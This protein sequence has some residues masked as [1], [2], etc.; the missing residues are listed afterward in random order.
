MYGNFSQQVED[1]ALELEGSND[2]LMMALG[3]PKHNGCVKGMGSGV[4]H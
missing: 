4:T 2:I 3:T 1:D